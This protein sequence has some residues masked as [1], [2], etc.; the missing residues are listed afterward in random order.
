MNYELIR[1]FLHIFASAKI[2]MLI[3]FNLIKIWQF[4]IIVLVIYAFYVLF[5]NIRISHLN[6]FFKK[7][8]RD[9]DYV[10]FGLLSFFLGILIVWLVFYDKPQIVSASIMIL[11]LGDSFATI[12]GKEFGKI[13]HPFNKDK[14]IQGTIAGIIGGYI[15]AS[16][17]V[18]PLYAFI[19]SFFSMIFESFFKKDYLG[20]V[21]DNLFVPLFAGIILNLLI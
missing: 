17:F 19:A 8:N 3:H 10:D 5:I 7:L 20:I 9:K 18:L 21:N 1:K 14:S 6:Y 13:K 2:A 12:I 16:F 11:S 15:G 4:A